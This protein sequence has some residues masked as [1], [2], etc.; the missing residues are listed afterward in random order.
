MGER[1]LGAGG[2]DGGA[3]PPETPPQSP[4]TQVR[5]RR[6]LGTRLCSVTEQGNQHHSL[7]TATPRPC[8]WTDT[9]GPRRRTALPGG[10]PRDPRPHAD[11]PTGPRTWTSTRPGATSTPGRAHS[12]AALPGHTLPLP[13]RPRLQRGPPHSVTARPPRRGPRT[14]W[15]R[16]S[17]QTHK[18]RHTLARWQIMA[19]DTRPRPGPARP[20]CCSARRAPVPREDPARAHLRGHGRALLPLGGT[21][22]SL[23]PDPLPRPGP[24]GL[25]LR[26]H[27]HGVRALRR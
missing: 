14:A 11:T 25:C 7:A 12:L 22:A 2:A 15:T 16:P 9:R 27:L 1:A 4:G 19:P 3:G 18:H 10:K 21:V 17:S 20:V 26:G 24:T 13:A 8:S 23:V 6:V 5:P